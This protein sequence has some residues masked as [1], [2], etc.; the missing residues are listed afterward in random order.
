MKPNDLKVPLSDLYIRPGDTFK[1]ISGNITTPY[2]KYSTKRY[3]KKNAIANNEWL[4][5]NAILEAQRRH[6]EHEALLM[7]LIN[8]NNCSGADLAQMNL[9]LFGDEWGRIGHAKH[10]GQPHE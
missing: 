7:N 8:P 3:T 9:F 10:K 2:P 5:Q 6:L 4:K 1:T